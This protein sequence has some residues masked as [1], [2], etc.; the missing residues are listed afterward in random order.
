MKIK[1]FKIFSYTCLITLLL[2]CEDNN[3]APAQEHYIGEKFDDG[4][5]FHVFKDS[6]RV[7]HG[8]IV[9]FADLPNSDIWS[10]V[11][12]TAVGITAQN[13]IDGRSNSEAIVAQSNHKKSAAKA[14][15]ELAFTN[16]N[17]WY[18][19]SIEELRLLNK[20]IFD[21]NRVLQGDNLSTTTP[22]GNF[23][24]WS[25]T[26]KTATNAWDYNPILDAFGVGSKSAASRIRAIKQF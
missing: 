9:A 10:N 2:G 12:D 21:V 4:V 7:Q 15:L 3:I 14:C 5:I 1:V 11:S 22:I 19:P 25:S 16:D 23:Y 20:N 8:L 17:P 18:L 6:S 26:E 24:Y 13:R